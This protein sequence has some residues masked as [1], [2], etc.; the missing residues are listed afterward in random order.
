MGEVIDHQDVDGEQAGTD[1]Y[2]DVPRPQTQAFGHTQEIEPCQCQQ[3]TYPYERTAFFTEKQAQ[4]RDNDDVKGGEKAR[5]PYR[6]IDDSKLL[7]TAC[8]A[9]SQSTADTAPQ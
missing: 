1:E 3:D 6:G 2:Q 4:Y 5:F 9:E 8:K 7:E